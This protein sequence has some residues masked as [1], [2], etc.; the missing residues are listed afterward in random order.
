MTD[1]GRGEGKGVQK[2]DFLAVE[3]VNDTVLYCKA[4]GEVG[5]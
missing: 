5:R 1:T 3:K 2:L 4:C